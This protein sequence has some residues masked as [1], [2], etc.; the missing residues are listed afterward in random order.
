MSPDSVRRHQAAYRRLL[1]VTPP[2]HR[3]RHGEQQVVLFGD[4]LKKGE[5]PIRLWLRALPDLGRVFSENKEVLVNHS[6]RLALGTISVGSIGLAALLG[7][8]AIEESRDIHPLVP[9]VALAL[10]IQG[11]FTLLWLAGRL[12]T[13]GKFATDVFVVGE[14]VALLIG[15]MA[16]SAAVMTIA[17]GDPEYGSML[18]GVVAA[19]HALIGLVVMITS[20]PVAPA[21][22]VTD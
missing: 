16:A 22:S 1:A 6:A 3:S 11:G 4:L 19:T 17:D 15:A 20:G 12:G 10:L 21:R 5:S 14:V 13:Q 9:V 18:V 2:T 7:W 8:M